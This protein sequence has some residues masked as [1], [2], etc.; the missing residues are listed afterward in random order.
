MTQIVE[1]DR[2]PSWA[3][4]RIDHAEIAKY[5]PA[6]GGTFIDAPRIES[7]LAAARAHPPSAARVREILA[8]SHAVQ[9]LSP[10]ELAELIAVTDPEVWQKM[11]QAAAEIKRKVY[12]NRIVTFA[13][14]YIGNR[15][16][17]NCLYCGLRCD[18][19]HMQ[20]GSLTMEELRAECKVLAGDIGHKRLIIVFG[21]HPTLDVDFMCECIRTIYDV[22]VRARIGNGQIRRVNVNAP[23][24][25]TEELRTLQQAGLGTYQVFQETYHPDT[26]AKVHPSGFKSDYAWRLY[27]MHRALEAGIDDVGIG[28]LFGLYDWRFEMMG[29]LAH[30]IELEKALGIGPHTISFPRMEPA[31]DAPYVQ[32]SKWTVSDADM[33]KIVTLIRLAVPYTGMILTARENA[34]M[35][36]RLLPLGVTQTDASSR[37][38][39]GAY[40][41]ADSCG[42]HEDRQQFLLG[43]TRSL[44]E[45]VRELGQQ[46][47]ITSF[48]TAGYRC[49]RTGQCIMDLLRS[50][51]EGKFCKLNAILTY[52]EWMD[53]FATPETR[54]V[55]EKVLAAELEE[56]RQKLPR[57][58]PKLMEAYTRTA[59]GERDV[60]F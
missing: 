8:K 25:R 42:Q 54:L 31:D 1:Q 5:L 18:N 57:A 27:T 22:K 21:E 34:E 35:R 6:A 29:L 9:T 16:V 4:S 58:Y 24:L 60:Y 56:V 19:T 36:R 11:R 14:L 43:D 37:I 30:A 23:P 51:T 52:R 39:V 10:E 49:G 12:D 20:R 44:D 15:C 2:A 48:C 46:G 45:L 50:G 33:E 53:D 47:L 41:E 55:G 32:D 28:A 59:S 38:G 13:P 26:Y 3:R 7:Q 17:N 40:H